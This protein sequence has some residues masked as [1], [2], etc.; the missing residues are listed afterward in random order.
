MSKFLAVS[1]LFLMSMTAV[2]QNRI[3]IVG[4]SISAGF[5]L[6]SGQEWAGVI[7]SARL[8]KMAEFALIYDHVY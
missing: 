8:N 7:K 1:L 4:D 6:E 3:L 2:A 5:G